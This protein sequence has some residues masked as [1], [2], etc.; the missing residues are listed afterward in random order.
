MGIY[1]EGDD[2]GEL[3]RRLWGCN[4]D[5]GAII[6]GDGDKGAITIGDGDWEGDDDCWVTTERW[7]C[8]VTN[9]GGATG[10][11][12]WLWSGGARDKNDWLWSGG[13]T[14]KNDWLGGI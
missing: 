4:G 2:D 1:G 11:N 7:A 12:D 3:W 8:G 5:K 9:G 14:G 13:A 10:K 6:I